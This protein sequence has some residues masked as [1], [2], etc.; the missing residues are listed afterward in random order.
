[1][2]TVN[3]VT[4]RLICKFEKSLS[5]VNYQVDSALEQHFDS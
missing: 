4:N 2:R 1:M 5:K 3:N